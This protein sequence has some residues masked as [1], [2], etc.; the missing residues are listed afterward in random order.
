MIVKLPHRIA[1]MCT[2]HDAFLLCPSLSSYREP[3]WNG[4]RGSSKVCLK[5]GDRDKEEE[6]KY[7][8]Y[9]GGE[10]QLSICIDSERPGSPAALPLPLPAPSPSPVP[11][12][13]SSTILSHMSNWSMRALSAGR[14]TTSTLMRCCAL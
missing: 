10:N 12:A 1:T 3:S 11:P 13:D 5:V 8:Y 2:F 14:E 7:I 9:L 4:E 6:K